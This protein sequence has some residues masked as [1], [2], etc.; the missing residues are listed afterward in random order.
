MS[1]P[2]I[3]DVNMLRKKCEDVQS[4]REGQEIAKELWASLAASKT[5]GV[6][7][8]A[9]QIGIHK[10]V[11]I[12]A[13]TRF[14][15]VFYNPRICAT[16]DK[17]V[18]FTEGC[19][20]IPDK[21]VKVQRHSY[22]CVAANWLDVNILRSRGYWCDEWT[23]YKV[24]DGIPQPENPQTVASFGRPKQIDMDNYQNL[25]YRMYEGCIIQHEIDH[26]YG[27]LITDVEN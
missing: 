9:P 10:K 3:T 6:G 24:V 17:D 12:V 5:P 8:A 16:G 14:D 20:S 25:I 2:I 7:L 18:T 1:L 23:G 19:L 13:T 27:R 4:L 15:W 22:F 21:T 11:C 26:L